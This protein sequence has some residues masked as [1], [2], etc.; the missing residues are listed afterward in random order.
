MKKFVLSSII[1]SLASYT[2]GAETPP[3]PVAAVTPVA[4]AATPPVIDCKY[5]V[6]ADTTTLDPKLLTTWAQ[7]AALQSFTFSDTKLTEEFAELKSCYTDQGWQ[8]FNN[9]LQKSGNKEAIQSQHLTVTSMADGDVKINPIKDNQWKI[10]VPLQVAYQNDKEKL[11][12]LLTVDLLIGRKVNG[13]LGI[14]QMI[15]TPRT[16]EAK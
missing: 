8:G 6:P 15:A 5:H 16:T 3:P 11:T 10:T 13:D 2:V 12:Q 7:K 1:L 14:M 9:A 4:T